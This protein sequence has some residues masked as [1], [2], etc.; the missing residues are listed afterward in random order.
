MT[1]RSLARECHG[2]GIM[3]EIIDP[4]ELFQRFLSEQTTAH[5]EGLGQAMPE[6]LVTRNVFFTATGWPGPRT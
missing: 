6:G 5:A 3:S 4:A 1:R 2:E